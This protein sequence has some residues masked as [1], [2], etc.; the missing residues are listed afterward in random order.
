MFTLPFVDE[1]L[2]G[3]VAAAVS[4]H[5]VRGYDDDNRHTPAGT[6]L[7]V[8]VRENRRTAPSDIIQVH[9]QGHRPLSPIGRKSPSVLIGQVE[10]VEVLEV[11]LSGEVPPHLR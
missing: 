11:L 5:C 6:N 4:D 10:C 1:T 7:N 9:Q 8:Q 2:A 3:A